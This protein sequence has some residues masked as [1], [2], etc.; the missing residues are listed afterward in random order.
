MLVPRPAPP[1]SSV[2]SALKALAARRAHVL[3]AASSPLLAQGPAVSW[4]CRTAFSQ[5]RQQALHALRDFQKPQAPPEHKL[6]SPPGSGQGLRLWLSTQQQFGERSPPSICYSFVGN[7][8]GRT[9]TPFGSS[10][11]RSRWDACCPPLQVSTWPVTAAHESARCRKLRVCWR[12]AQQLSLP[13]PLHESFKKEKRSSS[14]RWKEPFWAG[15]TSGDPQPPQPLSL[16]DSPGEMT[17][18]GEDGPDAKFF[19]QTTHGS[20]WPPPFT[21][22]L[23]Q[24]SL[25]AR[26]QTRHHS[27]CRTLSCQLGSAS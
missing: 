27:F 8:P 3:P 17:L 25:L 15:Q 19:Q 6:I 13:S 10:A 23:Q 11:C 26:V 12:A 5:G 24:G 20:T 22:G 18:P 1:F 16:L 2:C 4:G 14:S 9:E 7:S 21:E